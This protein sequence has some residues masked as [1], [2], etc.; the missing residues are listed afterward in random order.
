[1]FC[2]C[3][4][5]PAASGESRLWV[6]RLQQQLENSCAA[7][8]QNCVKTREEGGGVKLPSLILMMQNKAKGNFR[9]RLNRESLINPWLII[10]RAQCCGF[11]REYEERWA[12]RKGRKRLFHQNTSSRLGDEDSSLQESR[13]PL[14]PG[15]GALPL[16]LLAAGC[17]RL[18]VSSDGP[19]QET[20]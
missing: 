10:S 6:Q 20:T 7:V 8:G 12:A 13:V 9:Q 18:S 3:S 11:M 19:Q 14:S 2:S 1:M 16:T 4:D 15:T 17:W 5:Q